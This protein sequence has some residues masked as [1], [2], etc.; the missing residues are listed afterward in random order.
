[1]PLYLLRIIK[2]EEVNA[3]VPYPLVSHAVMNN[4]ITEK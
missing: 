1:M 4:L 3:E 2:V